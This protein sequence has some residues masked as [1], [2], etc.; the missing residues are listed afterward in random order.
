VVLIFGIYLLVS[1]RVR[2]LKFMELEVVVTEVESKQL[3]LKREDSMQAELD[4]EYFDKGSP[5]KLENDVKP[6]LIREAKKI[7]VLRITQRKESHYDVRLAH[8]YLECFTQTLLRLLFPSCH[9][10]SSFIQG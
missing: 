6:K 3:E 7:G 10:L 5:E 8:A 4:S 1:G 2:Q 9:L